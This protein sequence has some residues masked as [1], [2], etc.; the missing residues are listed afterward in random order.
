V[1]GEIARDFTQYFAVSEQQPG[2]VALGVR[3]SKDRT[4]VAWA[5]GFIV[6]VLPNASEEALD[7][8]EEKLVLM[9]DLTLLIQDAEGD[10]YKLLD[11]I[12]G[13][14]P[15]EFRPHVLEERSVSWLCD[16]SRDRMAK[17]LV[18]IGKKDLTEIIEEDHGAELT[19]QFC[20]KKY[21]FNEQE[22][23]TLLEDAS[24]GQD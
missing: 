19:C 2:S 4:H 21:Y 7:A 24:H 13:K 9:D 3:F 18:S 14:L 17:A 6:Q 16:C 22:L 5:G 1:S 20:L 10:P 15:E 8:L 12:F 11:I 23:R